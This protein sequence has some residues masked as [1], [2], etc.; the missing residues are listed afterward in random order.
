MTCLTAGKRPG[1]CAAVTGTGSPAHDD[2]STLKA[3]D[4]TSLVVSV[5]VACATAADGIA[6]PATALEDT[7]SDSTVID[8]PQ[9]DLS[10]STT[11]WAAAASLSASTRDVCVTRKKD[12]ASRTARTK[13]SSAKNADITATLTDFEHDQ[14]HAS[15]GRAGDGSALSSTPI[16]FR[17]PRD[18]IRSR[19]RWRMPS[20]SIARNALASEMVSFERD[21]N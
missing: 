12:I 17:S 7:S 6:P 19:T 10:S 2:R 13:P 11:F 9:P 14:D 3:E 1:V 20:S 8:T 16:S 21:S 18:L 4:T 15:S 5:V